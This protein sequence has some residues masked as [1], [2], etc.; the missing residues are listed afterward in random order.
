MTRIVS[1]EEF[2]GA[3]L[4]GATS[5]KR[6]IATTSTV[7][8]WTDLFLS[9]S[10]GLLAAVAGRLG[11]K[12]CGEYFRIDAVMCDAIDSINFVPDDWWVAEQLAVVVEHENSA[13][14]AEKEMNK[15]TIFDSPLKVLITYPRNRE[16][17]L[18]C[19]I[20]YA[21]IVQRADTFDDFTTKR[22]HLVIFG[23]ESELGM[24]WESFAYRSEKFVPLGAKP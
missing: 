7:A 10:K 3:F 20:T 18:G 5:Y 13:V 12:Y 21:D 4:D 2:N 16:H 15:L 14:G 11:L 23:Y 17:A 24:T 1:P 8:R 9:E 19:L 6:K 22:R